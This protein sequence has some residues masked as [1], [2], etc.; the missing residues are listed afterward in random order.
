MMR[1]HKGLHKSVMILASEFIS[2]TGWGVAFRVR[3][4][5]G[6]P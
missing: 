2:R 3:G 5:V 6:T 4:F 1:V